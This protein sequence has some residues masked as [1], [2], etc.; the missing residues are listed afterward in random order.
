MTAAPLHVAAEQGFPG[1]SAR[2]L[3][4]RH[5]QVRD[6]LT[7]ATFADSN[8]PFR[9]LRLVRSDEELAFFR[10]AAELTEGPA[11]ETGGY[12]GIHYLTSTSMSSPH[13]MA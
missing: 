11:L 6:A 1:F 13:A 4:R 8:G 10:L 12:A 3:E 5:H 9:R 7:D 2:E